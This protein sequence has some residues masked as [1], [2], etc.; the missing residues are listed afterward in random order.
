MCTS[1]GAPLQYSCATAYY[2]LSALAYAYKITI[3][4]FISAPGHGKGIVDGING[5][6]K[7]EFTIASGR[8]LM[9][10]A[11]THQVDKILESLAA[12]TK[13]VSPLLASTLKT[14]AQYDSCNQTSHSQSQINHLI[15][16]ITNPID[17]TGVIGI[18][19]QLS[20][21]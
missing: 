4:R 7:R 19:T 2:F 15:R 6:T 1:D 17:K 18:S 11:Q 13:T 3:D 16:Q 10:A 9:S 14:T 5:V 12:G 21:S 20:E 8:E